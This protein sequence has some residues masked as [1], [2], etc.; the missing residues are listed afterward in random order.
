MKSIIKV[1]PVTK[2][3]EITVTFNTLTSKGMGVAKVKGYT[4]FVEDAFPG[5]EARIKILKIG[6]S[7]GYARILKRIK[8][9]DD[10]V[11]FNNQISTMPLGNLKYEAQLR[12]KQNLIKEAMERIAKISNVAIKGI[13]GMECPWG[14]RNKAQV[15]IREKDQKLITGFFKKRSHKVIE[16]D[17]FYIQ[18]PKIDEAIIKIRE[19]LEKYNVKAYNEKGMTGNIRHIMVRRGFYTGELMIVLITRTV[20]FSCKSKIISSILAVLPETVSIVQNVNPTK[21]SVVLGKKTITLYGKDFYYDRLLGNIFAISSRS[22]YQINSLQTE[23]MYRCVI[24]AAELTG[25]ELV[26]DAYCGIG[27]ISLSL[28]PYAKEVLAVDILADAIVMAKKNAQ[29]NKVKNIR[30]EVGLAE[31]IMTKWI[32]EDI[33]MDVLIVDPPREGLNK[34]FILA[35]LKARPKKIIYVSCNPSTLAR[36]LIMFNES[37][38]KIKFIQPIDLFPQTLHVECVVSLEC[39]RY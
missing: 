18:D 25:K 16:K 32:K 1:C 9:S 12:F 15:P 11:A 19:I 20:K 4:L 3:E 7:F 30:F 28:A 21:T 34:V 8:V 2:D 24:Q 37:G 38:Y 17:D 14:Y 27:T 35:A 13:I 33:I 23:K 26:V 5:E 39:I 36:D 29:M 10:R 22:F 6:K 31:D